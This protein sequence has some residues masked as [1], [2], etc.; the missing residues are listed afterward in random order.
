MTTAGIESTDD[1]RI[2][3]LIPCF[4][5]EQT[6][7]KVVTDFME[8]LPQAHIYVYDNQSTDATGRIATEAGAT[9]IFSPNRGKGNVVRQ[10]FEDIFA[11]IYVMVDGDDTYPADAAP[12]LI[13]EFLTA[14]A[15][16]AVGIRLENPGAKSFRPLHKFGNRFVAGM[17]STLFAHKVQDVLSGYRVFSR[18][19]VEQVNLHS[20]K[21]EIETELTIQCL[22]K[23]L[24]LIEVPIPYR[25]RPEGSVSKLNTFGDGIAIIKAIFSIF[26]AKRP[27]FF[28]FL[29]GLIAGLLGLAA[30]WPP[31]RDYLMS[32]F[33]EHLPLAVLAAA[34]QII[35]VILFA[36]GIILAHINQQHMDTQAAIRAQMKSLTEGKRGD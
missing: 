20:K 8:A 24:K 5:E 12:R 25:A 3:V 28:F 19:F 13:D 1:Y 27:G 9:V 2:A 18:K 14:D 11:D 21:F 10:M 29:S 33:V 31:I 34:L 16:M 17:I 7:A 23:N 30:G 26:K 15:D 36:I 4:N 35:A 22:S 32:G 6:V